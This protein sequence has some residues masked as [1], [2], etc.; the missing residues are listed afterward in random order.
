MEER[1]NTAHVYGDLYNYPGGGP[2][3]AKKTVQYNLGVPV[4]YYVRIDFKGF[5]KVVDALGGVNIN[6][7]KD[8]RD[9]EFPDGNYGT[10]SIFIPAGLQHMDGK[11]ALQ[12]VRTRHADSDFGRTRRQLQFLVAM[13]DQ[14]LKL[15]ILPK[16]PSLIAQFRDSVKTD[17]SANE[18]ISLARLASQIESDHI[19]TRSIDET[20]VTPWV[21]PQG[22]SVLIP[23]RD[24][25]K[26]LIDEMFMP[27]DQP[28]TVQPTATA[29]P[30]ARP[31]NDQAALR[32]E[33]ARIEILN[34]TN[35][36]GLATR[37]R[38]YLN[39]IGYNVVT[40]GDAGRY[41]YRD[42]VIV[43]YTEKKVT[44]AALAKMFNVRPEN[45]RAAPSTRTDVD[46]RVILG[47]T[48]YVP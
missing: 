30:A 4:H 32:S 12:F 28:A 40:V 16:V 34:G 14:A 46:I 6:V 10:I 20:M 37:A 1:I 25:I 23:K 44:Q 3:L 9:D 22:G 36:K 48:A 35:T 31:G 8:I 29:L 27:V 24:E 18:I 5:E 38:N 2:A 21:T 39:S 17:L 19:V 42:T 47:S 26:K 41:D 33:N 43:Y 7:D 13:S 15:N 11:T 45:I